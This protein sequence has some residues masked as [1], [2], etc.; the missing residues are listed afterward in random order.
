MNKIVS[1]AEAASLI[2]DSSTLFFP[3]SGG[4]VMEPDFVYEGIEK[5][6]LETGSP[7][8]LTIFH[9][10][11]IGNRKE[12]GMSRFAHKGM[13][14][15]VVGG[16]W[17]WSPSMI[18]LALD[19]EIEAYCLPQG[20]LSLI[21]REIAAGR[22]GLI[23]P[24]G[25]RTFVD[26]RIDGGRLNRSAKDSLVE[27][28]E[29]G[30]RE[31]LFYRRFPVDVTVIRGTTADEDGNISMEFEAAD[32]DVLSSAQ[33]AYNSGGIVIAQVKRLVQRK[34]LRARDVEVPGFMV[35][36]V[37]EHHDQ[38]Q[39]GETDINVGYSGEFRAPISHLPALENGVRKWVARRAAMEL[40][41]GAVTNLGY[42]IA[43]G[44]ANVA[45]E[46]EIFEKLVFCIEQGLIGGIPAKGDIF[47]AAYNPDAII[48]APS[49][50][51]FFH[52]GGLD[53]A[54]LGMAEIDAK[55]NVNVSRFGD[56]I[57][58]TGGFIDI[59]QSTKEVVFCGTFTAGG[60]S[61]EHKDGIL[62]IETEG[63]VRKFVPEVEQ[64]TFSGEYAVER[65]QRVLYVTERAV[66]ELTPEGLMLIEVAPGLDLEKDIFGQ[67]GFKPTVSPHLM[68]MDGRIF[69]EA[70]IGLA[71]SEGWNA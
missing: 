66:F 29:V 40:K 68:T 35:T 45:A 22:P 42:G 59:S 21:S 9:I 60:L 56:R 33:A 36:A 48:D 11:G 37:V 26:P 71:A 50:F 62:T 6:F 70:P 57:T 13:V 27:V 12:R 28:I 25:L 53:I 23:T 18:R 49:Q 58:G 67:M 32:L 63:R 65:G 31:L 69:G 1:A 19:E 38:W 61:I 52:G 34:Q 16:H 4:G 10:S 3:G 17:G 44:V 54:F 24:I 5:R 41:P 43:D 14:R 64:I 30:G 8:N 7:N 55:G 51:D 39:T 20:V 46:E 15:R 2:K 47:G